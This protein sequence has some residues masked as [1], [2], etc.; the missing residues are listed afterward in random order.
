MTTY[1]PPT[2]QHYLLVQVDGT[3]TS[4]R[5]TFQ[6][7]REKIDQGE[8]ETSM[9][10]IPNRKV[11]MA[12]HYV[13]FDNPEQ[14]RMN[15]VANGIFWELS[16]PDPDSP[17]PDPFEPDPQAPQDRVIKMRGPVVF[18]ARFDSLS[19]DH[20]DTIR[21]AHERTLKRLQAKGWI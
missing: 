18:C 5:D 1:R 3:L 13:P 15:K 17:T 7:M 21:A 10:F 11:V 4:H 19:F 20:A 12:Y 2:A 8:G 9:E 14:Q 6:V 16:K